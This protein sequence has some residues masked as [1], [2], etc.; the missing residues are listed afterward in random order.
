MPDGSSQ[1]HWHG[2]QP[3]VMP[4]QRPGNAINEAGKVECFIL[5]VFT[6]ERGVNSLESHL[7]TPLLCM[8]N[9]QAPQLSRVNRVRVSGRSPCSTSTNASAGS[10]H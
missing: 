8:S 7:V 4:T 10:Q 9:R 5:T 6:L 1:S 2:F 3:W